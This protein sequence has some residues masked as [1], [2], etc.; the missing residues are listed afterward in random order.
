M[1]GHSCKTCVWRLL[2]AMMLALVVTATLRACPFCTVESRTLPDAIEASAAA[3]L[4]RVV[5]EARPQAAETPANADSPATVPM[6][7]GTATFEIVEVL[8]GGDR[9][10]PG[11]RIKVVYFGEG[12]AEKTFFV[13]G[14]AVENDQLEW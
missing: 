13:S 4:A 6:D 1:T 8:R 7:E 11:R 10:A 14:I 9:V 12:E 2:L 3:V 5:E